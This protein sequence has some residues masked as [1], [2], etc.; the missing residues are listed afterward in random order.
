MDTGSDEGIAHNGVLFF[1]GVPLLAS[2]WLSFPLSVAR[3]SGFLPPTFS[4]S[5]TNGV[6]VALPYYF[7]LSPNS[8]LTL[9]PRIMSKLGE[10]FTADYR[11]LQPN[12]SG[13]ISVAWL[14]H[15]AITN[16]DRYSIAVNQTWK[17]GSGFG[18]Y[19]NYNR[20]SDSTV[21]TDLASGVAFPTGSTTLYQ[22]EAGL[23][24]SNGPW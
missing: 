11:Y 4:F 16:T 14:P 22:Q 12:D 18:A 2:P 5:S 19:V 21:V 10:M 23:T 17:I 20:V 9:T 1:Q 6:D 8:D 13:S 3:R 24:Y 15:D 7:N